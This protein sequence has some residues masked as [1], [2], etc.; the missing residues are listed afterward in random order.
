MMN[1]LAILQKC[2]HP[3]IMVANEMLEDDEH[4]FIVTELLEGG[5]LFERL[6]E[7]G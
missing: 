1:E 6:L 3:N 5:E 7:I 4:Y 2:S